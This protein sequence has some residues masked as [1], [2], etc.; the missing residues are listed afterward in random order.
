LH[1]DEKLRSIA[2]KCSAESLTI[3]RK[4]KTPARVTG[5]LVGITAL[6]GAF[7]AGNDAG[8]AYNTFPKM[9]DVWV[10]YEDMFTKLPIWRNFFEN[11]AA[12]QFD[13]RLLATLTFCCI[14]GTAA[15][16]IR[17][18][19]AMILPVGVS[20]SVKAAAGMAIAQVSLGIS[21]LLLYVPIEL[22]AL[23]QVFEIFVM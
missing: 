13:H 23:H 19:R 22:A 11:T 15:I 7:V 2:S 8:R 14:G 5:V 10:P 4:L 9:G 21:T 1:P 6:S 18:I 12:V 16:A 20:H 3:C 17:G